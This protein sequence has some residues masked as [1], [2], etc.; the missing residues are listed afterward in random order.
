VRPGSCVEAEPPWRKAP[1]GMPR[2]GP[3]PM[4]VG[5][6]VSAVAGAKGRPQTEA[7]Q[8]RCPGSA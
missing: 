3:G 2:E 6:S 8:P 4:R 1:Q 7:T 5:F